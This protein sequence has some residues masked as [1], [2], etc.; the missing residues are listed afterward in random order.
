MR[1]SRKSSVQHQSSNIDEDTSGYLSDSR[2]SPIMWAEHQPQTQRRSKNYSNYMYP[3]TMID[4]AN[5]LNGINN[6]GKA[7]RQISPQQDD[8][9]NES[10]FIIPK[11]VET[12]AYCRQILDPISTNALFSPSFL[13]RTPSSVYSDVRNYSRVPSYPPNR[14]DRVERAK[15]GDRTSHLYDGLSKEGTVKSDGPVWLERGFVDSGDES[16]R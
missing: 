2:T 12:W 1:R 3:N 13:T 10:D 5:G 7:N 16:V 14:T 11:W 4:V 6:D 8:N 15:W 9:Y